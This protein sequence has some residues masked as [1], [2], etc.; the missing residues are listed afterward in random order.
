MALIQFE[1]TEEP[2]FFPLGRIYVPDWLGISLRSW[3]HCTYVSLVQQLSG[4]MPPPP[5][6]AKQRI[7]LV[8]ADILPE[9][10]QSKHLKW[11]TPWRRI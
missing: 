4:S 2:E 10:Q 3:Q 6:T 11:L 7:P 9:R 5:H 1:I 8:H